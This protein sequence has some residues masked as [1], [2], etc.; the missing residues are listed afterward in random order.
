MTEQSIESIVES[1]IAEGRLRSALDLMYDTYAREDRDFRSS[2]VLLKS[3]YNS[4][5]RDHIN[6]VVEI[7]DYKREMNRVNLAVL[8]LL[9]RLPSNSSTGLSKV[10]EPEIAVTSGVRRTILFLNANP[11]DTQHLRLD[12]EYRRVVEN[13]DQGTQR[14]KYDLRLIPA[15]KVETITQAIDKYRPAIVHFSGHGYKMDGIGV[16][17]EAGHQE[18]FPIEGLD[19]L[20]GLFSKDIGCVV[21]NSCYTEEQADIISRHGIHVVGMDKA[22]GDSAAIDFAIGFYQSISNGGSFQKAFSMGLVTISPNI[23]HAN[24][25]QLWY[26]GKKVNVDEGAN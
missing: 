23:P 25:P 11:K 16:E 20:F 14:D 22:I 6:G 17:N 8:N 10:G 12:E 21:L 2:L 15:I 18:I 24:T 9:S 19:R 13:Y 1:H 4:N 7:D 3:R 5:Q 26:N